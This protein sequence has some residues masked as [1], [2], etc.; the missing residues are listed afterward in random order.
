M[1][2]RSHVNVHLSAARTPLS[3]PRLLQA[4]APAGGHLRWFHPDCSGTQPEVSMGVTCMLRQ[5]SALHSHCHTAP[6]SSQVES[7]ARR[8]VGSVVMVA[9]PLRMDFRD[10]TV[11]RF[12]CRGSVELWNSKGLRKSAYGLAR[13]SELQPC[14]A[15]ALHQNLDVYGQ[16][17]TTPSQSAG[18]TPAHMLAA[19]RHKSSLPVTVKKTVYSSAIRRPKRR[20]TPSSLFS[21]ESPTR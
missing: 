3:P 14:T 6:T 5:L 18:R 15:A 2:H 1:H 12:Q 13:S 8:L 21:M 20:V 17:W 19:L 11:P 16:Y 10:S 9:L 7:S 4:G